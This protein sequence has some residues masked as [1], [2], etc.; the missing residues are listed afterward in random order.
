MVVTMDFQSVVTCPKLLVP[1][2]CYTQKLQLHSFIV[3]V[4]NNKDIFYVW[5]EEGG[6][7]IA[8]ECTTCIIDFIKK[9]MHY[10]KN[11]PVSDG[12]AYDK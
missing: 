1:K 8:I 9:N 6:K 7:I 11:N 5:H 2:Q 3:Y 4:S 10:K 12:C